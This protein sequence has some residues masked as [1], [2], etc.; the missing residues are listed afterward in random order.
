MW[1]YWSAL[2]QAMNDV[3]GAIRPWT[4]LGS[5]PSAPPRKGNVLERAT[6]KFVRYPIILKTGHRFRVTHVLDHSWAHLLRWTPTGSR[7]VVTVHDLIPLIDNEDVSPAQQARFRRIVSHVRRAD[8]VV[9]VSHHTAREVERLLE[10]SSEK[11]VVVHNGV[12]A[13]SASGAQGAGRVSRAISARRSGAHIVI[14]SIGSVLLRKNLVALADAAGRLKNSGMECI[15]A[16]GGAALPEL[17][18]QRF[19]SAVGSENLLEFGLLEEVELDE[20][21][22]SVD[23]VAVPSLYEGFGLPVVEAMAAGCPVVSSNATSLPEVGGDAVLYFDPYDTEAF[24]VCLRSVADQ[25][26][27]EQLAA[28]GRE[29]AVM[30]TWEAAARKLVGIY[31]TLAA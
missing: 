17:L 19:V 12:S 25:G 3:E 24:A 18:R 2:D 23:V 9:C 5:P 21:Y 26:R 28:A 14:G 11:I 10:I 20:F 16:R 4:P 6:W 1:K 29:R 8:C 7:R 31:E 30:F 22:A 15:V 13:R 27:R